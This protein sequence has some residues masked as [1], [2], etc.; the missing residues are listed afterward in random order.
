VEGAGGADHQRG[1]EMS[2]GA[3]AAGE[4]VW[5]AHGGLS[6]VATAGRRFVDGL[7]HR[8][9]GGGCQRRLPSKLMQGTT[10]GLPVQSAAERFVLHTAPSR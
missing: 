5:D 7:N 2:Q 8:D 3:A 4:G 9:A 1:A 10:L 6:W